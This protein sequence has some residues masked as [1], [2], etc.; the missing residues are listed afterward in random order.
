M[1][2]EDLLDLKRKLSEL[3]DEESKQRDLYLRQLALGEIQGPSTGYPSID[4]PW[5]K[6]FEDAE[7]KYDIPKKTC[8]ES[9]YE[10]NKDH[11]REIAFE[12][13]GKKFTYG[14]FF[15]LIE[16][17]KTALLASGIKK[18]EI[19]TICSITTPEIL[20]IF[21]ALNRIGAIPNFIDV[22]Y[23]PES[24]KEY[25]LEANSKKIF[26]LDICV[27]KIEKILDEV[28]VEEVIYINPANSSIPIIKGLS[29]IKS[30][31]D[32]IIPQKNNYFN[33]NEF[34]NRKSDKKFEFDYQKDYPAAIV[35]TGGTTGIPKGVVLSNDDFNSV[36]YQTTVART[37]Q[38]RGYKF[39]NI[40]PPFIAYG[41][42]LGLYAPLVL[43]WRTVI[44]PNFD[45]KNFSNL[46]KKYKPNG[47]MGVPIYWKNV[48]EDKKMKN[49]SLDFI[50]DVLVG[51]DKTQPSFER[52][53]NQFLRE[54]NSQAILSKGYSM[55]EAS[56]LATFSNK[57]INELGSVGI[58]LVKTKIA[59]FEPETQNE[60]LYGELGELCIQSSN[61]MVEYYNN[62]KE[63]A[64]VKQEHS[65]GYWIHSGDIG[66]VSNNGVVYVVDRIKRMIIRSGF[67]VFPSQIE[68]TISDID[69]IDVCAVVG[70]PDEIDV[71][72]PKA[73]IVLNEKC[74][75]S[76]NEVINEIYNVLASSKLPPYFEPV[77]IEIIDEMP[78]TIIG[79]IDYEKLKN[80]GS[81]VKVLKK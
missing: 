74:N 30:K 41:L 38:R 11:Q 50:E 57:K 47:V 58:P 1:T 45:A 76:E 34:I 33:W 48:M 35:H 42:G 54:H 64:K 2:K 72:A 22:R 81:K 73:Y 8:F 51:G 25:I 49:T 60:L 44:I 17:T 20:A 24:I 77:D 39:L 12:Y 26:T 21:Y 29:E 68:K 6:F 67:K 65:D 31:L 70:I 56:S 14:S 55:T 28:G 80:Y 62:E 27:P 79:K 40:M 78:I 66:Y 23:T 61:L 52:K 37:S 15:K 16:K 3:S 53:V 18:G 9:L 36:V 7:I 71:T 43:G 19:V 4:K 75:K 5:L 69:Y 10:N 32:K 13:L 63:T 46:L 59:A